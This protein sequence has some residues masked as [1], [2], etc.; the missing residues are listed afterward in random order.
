MMMVVMAVKYVSNSVHY[1]HS[2]GTARSF[3]ICSVMMFTQNTK[4]FAEATPR[5]WAKSSKLRTIVVPEDLHLQQ[6]RCENLKC[7]NS[8]LMSV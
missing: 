8:T 4:V 2:N 1:T 3:V 6:Y 5:L 7:R